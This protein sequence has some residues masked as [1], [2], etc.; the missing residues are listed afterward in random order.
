MLTSQW[1]PA[2]PL[3]H[4]HEYCTAQAASLHAPSLHEPPFMQG[5]DAHSAIGVHFLPP[6]EVS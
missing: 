1:E 2:Q 4:E 6:F 3:A 5:A